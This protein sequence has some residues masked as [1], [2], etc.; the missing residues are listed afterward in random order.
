M[1][2]TNVRFGGRQM[3]RFRREEIENNDLEKQKS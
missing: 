3:E 1:F 2:D